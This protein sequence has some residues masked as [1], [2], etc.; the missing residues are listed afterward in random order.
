MKNP[1]G[2]KLGVSLVMSD[3]NQALGVSQSFVGQNS[4][5]FKFMNGFSEH[6]YT[7]VHHWL[8]KIF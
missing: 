2:I 3:W 8:P 1:L 7:Q 6:P 5:G 4:F